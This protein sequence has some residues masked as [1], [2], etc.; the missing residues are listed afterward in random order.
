LDDV[1]LKVKVQE[2]KQSMP[3]Q[4]LDLL[5]LMSFMLYAELN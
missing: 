2:H 3:I 1:V 5:S 4:F